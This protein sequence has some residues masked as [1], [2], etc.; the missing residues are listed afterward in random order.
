MV[1]C[2]GCM[3]CMGCIGAK[4]LRP[5]DVVLGF[6]IRVVEGL[7]AAKEERVWSGV[8]ARE[9]GWVA[10]N[11]L[12]VDSAEVGVNDGVDQ[13]KTGAAALVVVW[14]RCG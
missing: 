10:E 11:A 1:G 13:S 7:S 8:M 3:G 9:E 4:A 2:I 14:A 12:V 5:L 6:G